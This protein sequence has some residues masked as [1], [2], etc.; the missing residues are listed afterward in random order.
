M[1]LE[2]ILRT[3]PFKFI[4]GNIKRIIL[5]EFDKMKLS[6][7]WNCEGKATSILEAEKEVRSSG[8][9]IGWDNIKKFIPKDDNH[10]HWMSFAALLTVIYNRDNDPN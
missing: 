8:K 2:Y 5:D 7:S 6:I 4:N 10:H 3:A 9:D 1:V